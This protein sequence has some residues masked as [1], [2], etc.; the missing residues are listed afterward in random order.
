MDEA[1]EHVG[2]HGFPIVRFTV[3][4]RWALRL[5]GVVPVLVIEGGSG[6][7]SAGQRR[8][9]VLQVVDEFVVGHLLAPA[10]GCVIGRTEFVVGTVDRLRDGALAPGEHS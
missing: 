2:V 6:D 7:G 5:T 4:S 1:R 8:D 3:I 10:G 9:H